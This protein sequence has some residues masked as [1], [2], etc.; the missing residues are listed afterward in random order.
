MLGGSEFRLRQG[1]APA[2]QNA[3]TAQTRR[4]P[5]GRSASSPAAAPPFQIEPASLGFDL[6]LGANLWV[7]AS[8]TAALL[9][10]K[11]TSAKAD[12]FLFGFRRPKGGST[13]RH[14]T[15]SAEVN[16]ACAKVLRPRRK[17]L[18]RRRRAAGQKAGLPV[19]L[20]LL[21]LSKSNPLRWASIWFWVPLVLQGRHLPRADVFLFCFGGRGARCALARRG[22][23]APRQQ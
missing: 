15:C 23:R 5:E 11:K 3:C 4:R 19:L 12:V 22:R 18:V 2:A 8:I 6:V 14:C 10:A 13:L 17:T 7:A 21:L 16:S 9:K 20:P 1:F